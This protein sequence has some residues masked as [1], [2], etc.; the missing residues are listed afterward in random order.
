MA[1]QQMVLGG[2]VIAFIGGGNMAGA[3]LGGLHKQ[4]VPASQIM[5][6]EP[7]AQA[8]ERL[9]AAY[10][11]KAQAQASA[12]LLRAGIVVWAVKPQIL[13]DV[14]LATRPHVS[15]SAL[16]LSIAAGVR[17]GSLQ[18]WLGT[19][20]LVRAMP[21]TP[22]LIGQG[23][24]GLYAHV[25]VSELQKSWVQEVMAAL[26]QTVWVDEEQLIDAV[27]AVSGSG[28]AYVYYFAEAMVQAGVT[29]GLSPE[30]ARLL[31]LETFIGAASLAKSSD[32][33][34][35]DLREQV[36]SKG[37][38]TFAALT[39]M[40]SHFVGES[41]KKGTLAAAVRAQQLGNELEK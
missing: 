14:A 8:R 30:Q 17:L 12:D 2:N 37:G 31:A 41:I 36:T 22:A 13:K 26:G 5:V 23:I 35:S 32:L 39:T 29:L 40:Q 34:L 3:M 11:V 27:T 7:N 19:A 1:M 33:S 25:D 16:H 24:S 20:R 10:G 15:D 38:T 4:G 28:P 9:E 18:K 6:V 21:N